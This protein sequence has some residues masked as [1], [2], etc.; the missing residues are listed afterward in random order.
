MQQQ[1]R[2]EPVGLASAHAD[3]V[4]ERTGL[5]GTCRHDAA[6]PVVLEAAGNEALAV[7]EQSR[8]ERVARKALH[9]APVEAKAHRPIGVGQQTA[10]DTAGSAHQRVSPGGG[11][12]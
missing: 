1:R 8:G 9:A 4:D 2:G 7:G 3:H 5:F 10:G 12:N 11:D 6:R